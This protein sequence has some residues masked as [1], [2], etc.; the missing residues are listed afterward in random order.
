MN[1]TALKWEAR[2]NKQRAC[3]WWSSLAFLY[4]SHF[5]VS[6]SDYAGVKYVCCVLPFWAIYIKHS[7]RFDFDINLLSSKYLVTFEA[8]VHVG[9]ELMA[10][11]QHKKDGNLRK[12]LKRITTPWPCFWVF[13]F[14]FHPLNPHSPALSKLQVLEC[15]LIY[16]ILKICILITITIP[17]SDA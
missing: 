12:V 9:A 14:L 7:Q 17:T 10:V 4:S 13:V 2:C 5:G 8:C 16:Q 15:N 3:R 1:F 6:A 11:I